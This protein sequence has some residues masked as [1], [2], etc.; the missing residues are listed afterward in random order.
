MQVTSAVPSVV[1]PCKPLKRVLLQQNRR[2]QFRQSSFRDRDHYNRTLGVLAV[3]N[4][5]MVAG[6][7]SAFI[8]RWRLGL[9]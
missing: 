8:A 6:E 2:P 3:A 4:G 7:S 5:N 9:Q 1:L